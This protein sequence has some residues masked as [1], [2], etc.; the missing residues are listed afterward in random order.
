VTISG[1]ALLIL[2]FAGTLFAADGLARE[3]YVAP[4]GTAGGDGSR[5]RPWSREA[6][7]KLDPRIQPMDTVW[8]RKGVYNGAFVSPLKG[9]PTGADVVRSCRTGEAKERPRE[10]NHVRHSRL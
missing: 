5:E 10:T 7:L 1:R 6:A 4:D 8:V 9:A 3:W 2:V